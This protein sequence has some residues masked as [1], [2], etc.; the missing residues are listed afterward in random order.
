M[1][2]EIAEM[3]VVPDTGRR[4][5]KARRKGMHQ[6]LCTCSGFEE[7]S[8]VHA[9]ETHSENA[10]SMEAR[11]LQRLQEEVCSLAGKKKKKKKRIE[12]KKRKF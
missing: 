10:Y 5:S 6:E 7:Q 9:E 4:A 3:G 11:C 12:R 1:L 8:L 2:T